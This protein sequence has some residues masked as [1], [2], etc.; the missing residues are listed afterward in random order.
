MPLPININELVNGRTVEWERIEFREGW[1]PERTLRNI[2]AFAN[3]FN[4]WGG[5][6][7]ILGIAK[8]N[9]APILPPQGLQLNQIEPIQHEL[10]RICRKII[11]EYFPIVEPVDFGGKKILIL[12]CSGGS[13]RPYKAP[14]TLGENSKYFF[15]IRR[16]SNTVRPTHDEEQEL[17]SMANRIPFDDQINH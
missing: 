15:F 16:Y 10:N 7:I 11:P 9:G 2:C 6:Y 13:N 1:N 4:N 3:D 5:G 8:K 14:E 12:W 17:L